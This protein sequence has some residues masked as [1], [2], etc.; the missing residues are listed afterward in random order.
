MGSLF[1]WTLVTGILSQIVVAI[2]VNV[3]G[4]PNTVSMF[5]SWVIQILSGIGVLSFTLKAYDSIESVR[6]SDLWH[7]QSFLNYVGVA[8]LLYLMILGGLIL[9]IVPGIIAALTFGLAPYIVIDKGLGT[10]AALKESARITKGNRLRFL[11]LSGATTLIMLIGILALFVGVF[12]AM[13]VI[14]LATIAAYRA[15]SAAADTHAAPQPLS[16]GEISLLVA[17]IL[18]PLLLVMIGIGSAIVLGSIESARGKAQ[19]A[20]TMLDLKQLQLGLEVSYDT[21]GS[22]P[23]KLSDALSAI[24]RDPTDTSSPIS[25]EG[26]TYTR[27]SDAQSY[28][29]CA[30]SP[31]S[32]R[33][34]TGQQCVSSEPV[35][36]TVTP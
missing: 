15:F 2:G 36:T 6:L 18:I 27:G 35:A 25:L 5:L 34:E 17:G 20:M 23:E 19:T 26:F 1:L 10:I 24:P 31:I 30:A 3:G 11:A 16:G 7:P 8:I 33:T 12:V 28:T 13:P 4:A 9:F 14:M 21:S 29:L 22:Y 32:P